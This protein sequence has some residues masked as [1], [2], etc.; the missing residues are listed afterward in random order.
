MPIIRSL[1]RFLTGTIMILLAVSCTTVPEET[2]PPGPSPEEIISG[3]EARVD[4]MFRAESGQPLVRAAKRPP[5]GPGRGNYVRHYSWSM[6]NFAT[7]CFYLDE[8]LDSA[9]AAL[10][11]NAQHYLDHPLDIND[12]DSFHW[13]AE[14]VMRLIEL[15]GSEG[16]IKPG[17]ITPETE[18]LILKPIW[19]YAK[20]FSTLE[21]SDF[22]HSKTWHI[23]G[24]ENH[25]AMS[26]TACWHFSK[27][28][29]D[30][31]EYLELRYDDGATA[32]AHY[33]S[34]NDYFVTYSRERSRKGV[35]IEMMCSGYNTVWTKGFY[36]FYDFGTPEVR[37]AAEQLLD[38]YWAYW[39][40]EQIVG[41]SGGGKSR[42]RGLKSYSEILHPLAW[43]FFGIGP[44]PAIQN[45]GP[46]L[47]GYRPPAVV[48]DIAVDVAGRGRFE[49]FQR[50]QGLGTRTRTPE[51]QNLSKLRTDG[52][53]ILRY[54]F[55]DPAF[56]IGTDLK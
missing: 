27:I 33:K 17:R 19:I 46:A 45:V 22:N 37:R 56:I 7:R 15:Y 40:Q 2:P 42:I 21:K 4:D 35:C 14:M 53:G 20:Q 48:A 52:G 36:N 38:L 29:K 28:A 3:F 5:L 50:A 47:S 34:W 55:C 41:I 26:F 16:S 9:N 30:R 32:E 11:E 8:M 6:M 39:A 31:P 51:G 25:H 12:R 44:R 49:V 54:S 13:H 23:Y 1:K 18:E 10:A 43:I 24:S